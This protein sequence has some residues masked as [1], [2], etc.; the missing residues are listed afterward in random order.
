MGARGAEGVWK[1]GEAREERKL[2]L[3]R[4]SKADMT[5]TDPIFSS[6]LS[7][8]ISIFV[9]LMPCNHCYCIFNCVL[10]SICDHV[11]IT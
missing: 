4:Y 11:V 10:H 6:S 2:H 1:L 8:L 7:R 3:I 9:I 5:H